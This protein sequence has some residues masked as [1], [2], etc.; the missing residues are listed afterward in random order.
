MFGTAIREARVV[1]EQACAQAGATRCNALVT[2]LSVT[3]GVT[4]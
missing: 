4:P 3:G 2:L 1:L